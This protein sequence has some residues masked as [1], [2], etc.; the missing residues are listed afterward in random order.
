MRSRDLFLVLRV[1]Q[2][3]DI[4]GGGVLCVQQLIYFMRN[5]PK[6][7]AEMMVRAAL[8]HLSTSCSSLG[9]LGSH[10]IALYIFLIACLMCP[11]MMVWL[12]APHHRWGNSRRL[13]AARRLRALESARCTLLRQRASTSREWW[14]KSLG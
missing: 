8:S 5:H 1:T 4:R 13:G 10:G 2:V 7:A 3:S 14:R 12:V 11:P 9:S 6:A